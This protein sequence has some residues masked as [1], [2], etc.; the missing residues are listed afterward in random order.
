LIL[1]D[2]HSLIGASQ[3]L[4]GDSRYL[5]GQL[6]ATVIPSNI[7]EEEGISRDLEGN[8]ISILESEV[9]VEF[10][11]GEVEEIEISFPEEDLE[12]S[13]DSGRKEDIQGERE[14]RR[15]KLG[16]KEVEVESEISK[17]KEENLDEIEHSISKEKEENLEGNEI[18]FSEES[19]VSN[20]EDIFNKTS[21][22][23]G[24]GTPI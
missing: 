18:S 23:G 6:S 15:R 12:E 16:G 7:D 10:S 14:V 3:S 4:K 11:I 22:S 20:H 2:E 24:S 13:E 1:A 8:E 5:A 17:E 21:F 9:K 19:E